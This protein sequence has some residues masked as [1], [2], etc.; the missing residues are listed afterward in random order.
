MTLMELSRLSKLHGRVE[1]GVRNTKE[2]KPGRDMI[3]L[4][5]RRN[6]CRG[7]AMVGLIAAVVASSDRLRADT[8]IC[9]GASFTLPFTDVTSSNIFFCSIAEAF[10]AGLTNGTG[11]TTYSPSQSVPRE[12]MA[13]FITR[14][15]DQSVKRSSKRA[16]LRQF[17]TT[18]T[19]DN[20]ALTSVDSSPRLVESDGL[21]IW[22]ANEGSST[23]SRVRASDGHLVDFWTGAPGAFGVLV[24]MG[25]VFIAGEDTPGRLYQIDPGQAAGAVTL[26]SSNLGVRPLGIA[27][28]G[29]R[30][31]TANNGSP[32]SIP[33]SVSIV[34][35]NPLTV[36]NVTT[37]F[38]NP[39]GM[40]F[41]GANIWVTDGGDDKLKMLDSA[42]GIVNSVSVGDVPLYPAFDGTNI[43][44]PNHNPNTVSVVRVAGA[45]AGT[46]LATLSGNGLNGPQQAA[47]DGES[48]SL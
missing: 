5:P 45:F 10:V 32:G 37:G 4:T 14:T 34:T 26:V 16:A 12:Q 9:G 11:A 29:R 41:D 33:G 25:K 48:E 28:D 20:L 31:W 21:D 47:F 36:T 39:F 19:P 6:I 15:M 46:V 2:T 27:Y 18:Q 44:V 7:L 40:I 3:D 17:W 23:V 1:S 38:T 42:G 8:G 35:L 43:W 13:A 24:A 22:V 30:I